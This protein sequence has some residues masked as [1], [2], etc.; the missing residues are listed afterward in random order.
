[1]VR[2]AKNYVCDR[3][4]RETPYV[5]ECGYCM[6]KICRSCEK[7]SATHSKLSRTAIC[8]SCWSDMRKRTKFKS[9]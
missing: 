5:E 6:R 1:M 8:K 7:S 3:C 9:A 2:Q 4:K